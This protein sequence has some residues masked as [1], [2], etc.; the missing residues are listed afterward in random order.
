MV[1]EQR[2]VALFLT[3][4]VF[5]MPVRSADVDRTVESASDQKQSIVT[6]RLVK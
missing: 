3:A 1:I 6:N 2:S 4:T 5:G